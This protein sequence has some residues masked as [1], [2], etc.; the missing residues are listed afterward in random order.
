M[1]NAIILPLPTHAPERTMGIVK[2]NKR[3]IAN[4]ICS[5]VAHPPPFEKQ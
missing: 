5:F 4:A 3:K 2:P 1:A